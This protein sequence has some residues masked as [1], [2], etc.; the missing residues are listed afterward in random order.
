MFQDPTK[1]FNDT[2]ISGPVFEVPLNMISDQT[3]KQVT[4]LCYEIYGDAGKI[5]NLIS[6]GCVQVN[7]EYYGTNVPVIGN[8][9]SKI[10]IV[11][12][13]TAGDCVKVEV[14]MNDCVPHVNGMA[15]NSVGYNVNGVAV[16]NQN[17][18]RVRIN[19]PNC[20]T[21][22]YDDLVFWITCERSL[23]ENLIKFQVMRGSGLQP[24]AHGLIGN[25]IQIVHVTINTCLW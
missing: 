3:F 20:N 18:N 13:D 23:G 15:T 12:Y 5:F 7:A 24:D 25:Y 1:L 16:A 10:G 4:A 9:I 21:S 8:V 22:N 17:K 19:V 6:D 2:L 14:G 11:A